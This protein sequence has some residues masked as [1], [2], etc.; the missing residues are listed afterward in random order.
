MPLSHE[1]E[2]CAL[3]GVSDVFVVEIGLR[4]KPLRKDL[5]CALRH[6]RCQRLWPVWELSPDR[7]LC[8]Q[9]RVVVF[10]RCLL[11]LPLDASDCILR[12]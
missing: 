6:L 5:L 8:L 12:S 4:R 11:L 10:S 9:V 7:R 3:E 2:V 1:F